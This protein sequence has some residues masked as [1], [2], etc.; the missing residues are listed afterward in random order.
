[1]ALKS[2]GGYRMGQMTRTKTERQANNDT[3]RYIS[4]K[5]VEQCGVR[6]QPGDLPMSQDKERNGSLS[7]LDLLR[8]S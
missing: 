4:N 2:V 7:G 6:W 8:G 5:V 1:M 3:E